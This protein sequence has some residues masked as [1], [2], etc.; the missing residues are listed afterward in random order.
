MVARGE[1]GAIFRHQPALDE[2]NRLAELGDGRFAGDRPRFCGCQ[3]V[4][5]HGDGRGVEFSLGHGEHRR[6]HGVVEHRRE[7][8]ALDEAGRVAEVALAVKADPDPAVL[9]AGIEQVPAEQCCAWRR[10]EIVEC[11]RDHAGPP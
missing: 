2:R 4:H 1:H 10:G 7:D 3:K 5:R 8:A 6:A 9:R 11:G